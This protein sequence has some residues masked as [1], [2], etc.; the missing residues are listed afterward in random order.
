MFFSIF[1]CS[2]F[3]LL[4]ESNFTMLIFFFN[5]LHARFFFFL[6]ETFIQK[7]VFLFSDEFNFCIRHIFFFFTFF[8]FFSIFILYF[9]SDLFLTF[10]YLFHK[11]FFF[12]LPFICCFFSKLYFIVFVRPSL[13]FN[14]ILS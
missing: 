11:T 9:A 1:A 4:D 13:F 10:L 12:V 8:S 7:N 5:F 6:D 2:F 14:F 3:I